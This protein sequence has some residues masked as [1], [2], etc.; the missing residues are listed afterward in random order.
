MVAERCLGCQVGRRQKKSVLVEAERR[1]LTTRTGTL[2]SFISQHR[3][4]LGRAATHSCFQAAHKILA[5]SGNND[6]QRIIVLKLHWD[7]DL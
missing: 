5:S 7:K 3:Q 1:I 6:V 2:S 4:A